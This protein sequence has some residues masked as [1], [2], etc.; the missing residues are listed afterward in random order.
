MQL[1]DLFPL[2]EARLS[3]QP[4]FYHGTKSRFEHF[5]PAFVDGEGALDQNGPGFYFT[6]SIEEAAGYAGGDG[7]ILECVLTP[8]KLIKQ[9]GVVSEDLVNT[10]IKNAPNLE[11]SLSNWDEDP[12]RAF[13]M[14]LN[15]MI[16]PGN[17]KETY[18]NVWGDFYMRN[19]NSKYYMKL[20][21]DYKYDGVIVPMS[22]SKQHIIMLN[23]AKIKIVRRLES[24][25]LST[26]G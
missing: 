15:A 2:S 10:L 21:S 16:V 17:P 6:N 9:R 26:P 12:Q 7:V 1:F 22:E 5:D 14:A 8:R 23:E 19:N 13:R 20:M 25:D 11:D 4:L 3:N 24:S 18:E